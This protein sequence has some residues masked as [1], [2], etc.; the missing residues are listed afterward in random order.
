MLKV[1]NQ[2]YFSEHRTVIEQAALD[3]T[4]AKDHLDFMSYVIK[5]YEELAK[6]K[7]DWGFGDYVREIWTTKKQGV[8]N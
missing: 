4:E 7:N 5:N 8:I 6:Y 3:C 1:V 2:S